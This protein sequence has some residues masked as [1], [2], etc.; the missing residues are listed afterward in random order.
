[1][2]S[3]DSNDLEVSNTPFPK[4]L[5]ICTGYFRSLAVTLVT[6]RLF[7]KALVFEENV[8]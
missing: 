7:H 6:P 1:M 5:Q 4:E 2:S 3:Y 8:I